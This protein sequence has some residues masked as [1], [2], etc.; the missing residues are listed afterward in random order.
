MLTDWSKL[1]AIACDVID[2]VNSEFPIIEEWTLGGGTALMLQIHHRHSH[3]VDIFIEDGQL[4]A[5]LDPRKATFRFEIMPRNYGGDGSTFQKLVFAELGE[6]DFI[7]SRQVTS[8]PFSKTLIEGRQ[9]LLETVGEIIA[10]KIFHRGANI[11]PRDIFDLAAAAFVFRSD[12]DAALADV[13]EK[14]PLAIAAIERQNRDYLESV[15][16][17]LQILPSFEHLQHSAVDHA[18]AVL[19]SAAS[20]HP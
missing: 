18:L 8:R 7:V 14:V 5:F 2:Q 20:K 15:I 11:T 6:V 16:S 12:V 1:F 3:D 17:D 9:I 10:K 13:V 4:L 19:R